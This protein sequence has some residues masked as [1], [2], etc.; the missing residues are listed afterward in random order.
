MS[1]SSTS[2]WPS[3]S[4]SGTCA[5][6]SGSP[7]TRPFG[8]RRGIAWECLSGRIRRRSKRSCPARLKPCKALP[9]RKCPILMF[10]PVLTFLHLLHS[11]A[12]SFREVG[13]TAP[14]DREDFRPK[15]LVPFALR[16]GR[17]P[18][19]SSSSHS[20]LSPKCR[21][22]CHPADGAL[23]AFEPS[24]V[25]PASA[26]RVAMGTALPALVWFSV[27]VLSATASRP[28]SH[29]VF[30]VPA[31]RAPRGAAHSSNRRSRQRRARAIQDAA[32][33]RSPVA[34]PESGVKPCGHARPSTKRAADD[35][36]MGSS[37]RD[38]RGLLSQQDGNGSCEQLADR[39]RILIRCPA[40]IHGAD[41][42]LA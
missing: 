21:A 2:L 40:E 20:A 14:G 15:Y 33:E 32:W 8:S 26:S 13:L 27:L 18:R 37:A 9:L 10:E 6:F 3:I 22:G 5:T 25:C 23:E 28:S 42:C 38:W 12:L 39:I 19:P 34:C 30:A 29:P 36:G 16:P 24:G 4:R 31:I 11:F 41:C 1:R 35:R 7:A 17:C